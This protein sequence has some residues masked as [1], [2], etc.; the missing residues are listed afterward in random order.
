MVAFYTRHLHN[1]D[2][3]LTTSRPSLLIS[4]IN[5][6]S[7]IK[8]TS[9]YSFTSIPFPDISLSLYNGTITIYLY[10]KV[11]DKHQYLFQSLCHPRHTKR[12]IP[13]SL[14]LRLRRICSSDK[15]FTLPTNQFKT[16]LNKLGYNLS[17]LNP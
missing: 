7:T 4:V 13:C 5:I 10:T 12:A 14:A 1:K 11:T 3:L 15:T 6:H 9:N 8:F 2:T 17:F 16:Y